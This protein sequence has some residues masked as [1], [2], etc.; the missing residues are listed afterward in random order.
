MPAGRAG[1]AAEKVLN[2]ERSYNTFPKFLE[3]V[4]GENQMPI[5][6]AVN[7]IT[8]L[9]ARKFGIK[10]S[11]IIAEGKCADLAVIQNNKISAVIVNGKIAVKNGEFQNVSAGKVLRRK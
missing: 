6:K 5:E 10:D 4:S 8:G 2:H 1:I 11:G 9:P 7:K 3:I